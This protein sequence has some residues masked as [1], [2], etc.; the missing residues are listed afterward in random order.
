MHAP[1]D[2]GRELCLGRLRVAVAAAVAGAGNPAEGAYWLAQPA[3][4]PVASAVA[5]AG[6]SGVLYRYRRWRQR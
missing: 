1:D 5:G 2:G 6:A 3:A 4:E